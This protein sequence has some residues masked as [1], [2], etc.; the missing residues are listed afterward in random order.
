MEFLTH[1]ERVWQP[2]HVKPRCE[3]KFK[4][5]QALDKIKNKN[6]FALIRAADSMVFVRCFP[7]PLGRKHV[8]GSGRVG[9]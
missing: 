8:P 1:P 4:L 7:E 6:E 2:V 3:K 9:N 5:Y